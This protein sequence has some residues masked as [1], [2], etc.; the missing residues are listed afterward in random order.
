MRQQAQLY[1]AVVGRHEHLAHA[2][3]HEAFANLTPE[4]SA[5]GNVLQVGIAAAQ[6]P[7]GGDGLIERRMQTPI[8]TAQLRQRVDIGAFDLRQF[9]VV[10]NERWQV[11]FRGQFFEHLGIGGIA[12]LGL[13]LRLQADDLEQDVPHLLG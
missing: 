9:A 5:H 10:Q 2:Q 13:L 7:R 3:R 6:T 12:A 8:G 4:I 11:V 1:L